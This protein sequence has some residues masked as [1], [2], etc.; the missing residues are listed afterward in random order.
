[1]HEDGWQRVFE[2]ITELF[3]GQEY[4]GLALH[5]DVLLLFLSFN[6]H[7]VSKLDIFQKTSTCLK[8]FVLVGNIFLLRS[9]QKFT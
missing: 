4:P 9:L 7:A 2:S 6:F 8:S 5:I 1:M 3:V